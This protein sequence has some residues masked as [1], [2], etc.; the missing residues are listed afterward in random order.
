MADASDIT[1]RPATL[2]DAEAISQLVSELSRQFITPEYT[3]EGAQTLLS[4]QTPEAITRCLD[5][6]VRYVV[7][8]SAG[9]LVAAGGLI[10]QRR[11]LYHLFVAANWQGQGIGRRLWNKLTAGLEPGPITVNSSRVAIGFYERLGFRSNGPAW[12]KDGVLAWPMVWE[13]RSA[14]TPAA[15]GNLSSS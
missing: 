14:Q 4:H 11:H 8:E 7:A 13:P 2:T 15:T 1:I 9:T 6:G 3:R 5:E 12:N 10:L